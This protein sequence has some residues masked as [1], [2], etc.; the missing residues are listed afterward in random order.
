MS[1]GVGD[2]HRAKR[3]LQVSLFPNSD[4]DMVF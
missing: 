1:G 2:S 4:Q 3:A